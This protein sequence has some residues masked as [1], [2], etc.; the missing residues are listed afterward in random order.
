MAAIIAT[1]KVS[2]FLV[3]NSAATVLQDV[4]DCKTVQVIRSVIVIA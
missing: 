2:S 3:R 4:Q 1:K